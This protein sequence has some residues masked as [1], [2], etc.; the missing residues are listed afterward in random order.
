MMSFRKIIVCA[1]L[2]LAMSQESFAQFRSNPPLEVGPSPA[3]KAPDLKETRDLKVDSAEEPVEAPPKKKRGS[4]KR[5]KE[6]DRPGALADVIV[7]PLNEP[8][9]VNEEFGTATI[10][11]KALSGKRKSRKASDVLTPN[12]AIAVIRVE[13]EMTAAEFDLLTEEI[14]ANKDM[15]QELVIC[16]NSGGGTINDY[17][18][19]YHT[20]G[21]IRK[22][23]LDVIVCID[24]AACSG[25]YLMA[26]PA[27]KIIAAELAD[28]GSL[29]PAAVIETSTPKK[30]KKP[31]IIT[32]AKLKF[33]IHEHQEPSELQ[34]QRIQK[35]VDMLSDWIW[36]QTEKHRPQTA[37]HKDEIR[38]GASWP[39]CE[40]IKLGIGLVDEIGTSTEYLWNHRQSKDI[41]EFALAGMEM[42][43]DLSEML[44][45]MEQSAP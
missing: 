17:A 28:V 22:A 44:G 29:A 45:G 3:D 13:E 2:L 18:L 43:V 19:K 24:E 6:Q 1:M 7:Q 9:L 15:F 34:I 32:P 38:D 8:V 16:I 11:R 31:R 20:V 40:S 41:W 5:N 25:G 23:G 39:A 33:P 27:T 36:T 37:K 30:G 26:L 42:E 21:R 4:A 35:E 14:L 12:K 10:C